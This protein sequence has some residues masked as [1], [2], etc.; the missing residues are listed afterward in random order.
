MNDGQYI[1]FFIIPQSL[2][3]LFYSPA[4]VCTP[5]PCT[6]LRRHRISILVMISTVKLTKCCFCSFGS[7]TANKLRSFLLLLIV[8]LLL[9]LCLASPPLT[10]LRGEAEASSK[11][12]EAVLSHTSAS[13]TEALAETCPSDMP[14][15]PPSLRTIQVAITMASPMG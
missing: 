10:E 3:L 2:P 1:Y 9:L 6:T 5:P 12:S 8:Y 11:E 14:S 15:T 13:S 4:Y 7:Y